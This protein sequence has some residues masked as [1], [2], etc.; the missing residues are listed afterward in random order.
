MVVGVA[1]E[2]RVRAK[3]L[4]NMEEM[5]AREGTILMVLTDGDEEGARVA[6]EVLWIPQA[7]ELIAPVA[8][9]MPLQL[10]AYWIAKER[11]HD[12]D[13]PRNLAKTVTVE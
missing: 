9:V 5:R 2:G 13:K 11:G 7:D 10:L 12:V 6:D 8:A 3:T 4:S 1:P